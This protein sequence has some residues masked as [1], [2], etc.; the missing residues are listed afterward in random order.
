[1]SDNLSYISRKYWHHFV[2]CV[3][4]REDLLVQLG[5]LWEVSNASYMRLQRFYKMMGS[6]I[7]G[8]TPNCFQALT[9]CPVSECLSGDSSVST[10]MHLGTARLE[11]LRYK[12]VKTQNLLVFSAPR[13]I[14]KEGAGAVLRWQRNRMGR[15][16]SPSQIH[17][18]IIW[19]LYK[20]HKTT[21]ECWRRIPGTQKGSPFSLKGGHLYLL[22]PSSL[23]CLT[24]L[25]LF[26]CSGLWR[27]LR[28][29]IT[30]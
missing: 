28:E 26:G 20:F 30:G 18:K 6:R 24:L 23:L 2:T 9:P 17:Q 21:S 11:G 27:T 15:P 7:Q 1:M 12:Q 22:P 10:D 5:C 4:P 13:S 8:E 16:L 14:K 3:C 29:L 19:M 25:D